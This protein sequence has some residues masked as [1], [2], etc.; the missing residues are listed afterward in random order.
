LNLAYIWIFIGSGLGG[1]ARY[2]CTGVVAQRIG[3]S[4]PWGTLAV[5]VIGCTFIGLFATVSGPEGR[6]FVSQPWRQLVMTGICGGFTTFS[7]FSLE[8][9]NLA[10]DGQWLEAAGNVCVSAA[11]CLI[12]VWLGYMLGVSL[13]KSGG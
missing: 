10:R 11:L 9:L 6:V 5:N 7:T 8:T 2:L 13:N 1:A 3:E 12:G 4:F